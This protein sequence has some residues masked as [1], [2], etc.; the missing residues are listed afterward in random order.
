MKLVV[1]G[2]SLSSSWGNGHATTYR[3]LLRAFAA[4][5]HQVVF[6]EWDAPWYGGGNRD[7]P[8]PDFCRLVAL[9]R[10]GGRRAAGARRGPGGRRGGGGLLRERGPAADR[11]ACGRGRGAALLLR[12][13]HPRDGGAAPARAARSTFAPDQVPLFARYLSFTG[14]PFL[15]AGGGGG[16]GSTRGAAPLLLRGRARA[17]GARRPDPELAVD[18]GYMGTYAPD[19][20]PVVERFLKEVARRLP[21]RRF[22]VAGPQY[23]EEMAWPANVRI[24]PT[25]PPRGTRRS[26]PAPAGS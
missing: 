9:R 12:H 5:G 19:R 10:L 25:S 2:L 13:R 24:S 11:R 14:G 15:P 17:T 23:P 4:R 1:F 7:L 22:L 8:D 18:L 26:T 16:A 20:Q 6:Y 21:E 3:A